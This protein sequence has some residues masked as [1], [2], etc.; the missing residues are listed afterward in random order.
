M[1]VL[2]ADPSRREA[3]V[4]RTRNE[5]FKQR[6]RL[7]NAVAAPAASS[8][9]SAVKG[10]V[11]D[12][13]AP[14]FWGVRTI[15]DVDLAEVWP[16]FDLR[17]LFRLSWG[18]ANTKGEA[19]EALLRDDFEPRLAR[20]RAEAIR[21]GYLQP[22]VV[23]GYFPAA[24][25]GNEV[26]VYD[27]Q[28]RSRELARFD[29]PRQIGGEHL[30]LADYL[31]EP[32]DGAASDVIALQVV[33]VGTRA[34]EKTEALQAAGNYSESYFLHGFSVQA[35]EALAEYT[36]QRIRSELGLGGDRGKRYSWGYGACPDLSQHETAFRLLEA[37]ER[38]GVTLTSAHQIVPE[39]STAAIVMHHP[40]ASYFNAAA[41]RELVSS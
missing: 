31:R 17:S 18:A 22:R 30:S 6:D 15:D 36:H 5:A 35:A 25:V 16:C 39:Q 13:P 40:K 8:Q 32:V 3:L 10:E 28:D 38:I 26:I 7:R 23:Y 14:P 20:Y 9:Y 24:S 37:T 1:D 41:V 21:E 27:P 34:A 12:V 29:F 33:T 4:E 19:F 2:T 11:A